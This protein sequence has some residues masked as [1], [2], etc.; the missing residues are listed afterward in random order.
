LA[1][2]VAGWLKQT[3]RYLDETLLME[4]TVRLLVS[5]A[6]FEESFVMLENDVPVGT[7]SLAAHDLASRPDLG[8]WISNVYV[9]PAYRRRGYASALI[10]HIE[11]FARTQAISTLWL[12][13]LDAVALYERLGW[14]RAGLARD[15]YFTVVLMRRD[16]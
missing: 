2:G 3:F 12:Y 8:P 6:T 7:A 4:I 1:F 15:K 11:A 5:G 16:L 13:T 10:R 9:L 14:H